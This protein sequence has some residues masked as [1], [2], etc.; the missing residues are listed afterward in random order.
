MNKLTCCV[1][2]AGASVPLILAGCASGEFVGLKTELVDPADIVADTNKV[3][4]EG[5][6][7]RELD[8]GVEPEP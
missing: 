1:A 5:H 7:F 4:D 6:R 3:L 8:I 2:V